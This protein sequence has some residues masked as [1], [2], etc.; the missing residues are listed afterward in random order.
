MSASRF[1]T[2]EQLLEAGRTPGGLTAWFD[3]PLDG[4]TLFDCLAPL[5][6][7]PDR[8]ALHVFHPPWW[9][10]SPAWLAAEHVELRP[11]GSGEQARLVQQLAGVGAGDC[12]VIVEA[13]RFSAPDEGSITGTDLS[14]PAG[15]S[16]IVPWA[17]IQSQRVE[18]LLRAWRQTTH[19]DAAA[20][21]ILSDQPMPGTAS[22]ARSIEA[23]GCRTADIPARFDPYAEADAAVAALRAGAEPAD[24]VR[25]IE[26][27]LP[28]DADMPAVAG[29]AFYLAGDWDRA[30]A[31]LTRSRHPSPAHLA[32]IAHQLGDFE[33]ARRLIA[34]LDPAAMVDIDAL[35]FARDIA[36][37]LSMG[38]VV[39]ALGDRV[40]ALYPTSAL[41]LELRAAQLAE[42]ADWPDL[43]ALV[44]QAPSRSP[45]LDYFGGLAR[46][47]T[48]PDYAVH[49][50]IDQARRLGG[51]FAAE[52]WR[53][54][55]Q[56]L[57]PRQ[58]PVALAR[59]LVASRLK[60][61]RWRA[62][63]ELIDAITAEP[64]WMQPETIELL[65]ALLDVALTEAARDPRDSAIRTTIH[66][67]FRPGGLG[68]E[69]EGLLLVP[70]L[71]PSRA[72]RIKATRAS[73]HVAASE[74]EVWGYIE[75]RLTENLDPVRRLDRAGIIPPEARPAKPASML[76]GLLRALTQSVDVGAAIFRDST[77]GFFAGVHAALELIETAGG[78]L[79]GIGAPTVLWLAG[80]AA[81]ING[82]DQHALQLAET[83]LCR[84]HRDARQRR[85]AWFVYADL[86]ARAGHRTEAL[87]GYLCA[88]RV[89]VGKLG[90]SWYQGELELRLRLARDLGLM[91]VAEQAYAEARR[92]EERHR[93]SGGYNSLSDAYWT[94]RLMA[95]AR[96]APGEGH[97]AAAEV[98]DYFAA[99][100]TV[101]YDRGSNI[102]V[103]LVN[104]WSTM[105]QARRLGVE[106][107]PTIRAEFERVFA[108]MPPADR[109]MLKARCGETATLDDLRLLVAPIAGTRYGADLV[110]H[111][112]NARIV[113]E[114]LLARPDAGVVE[115]LVALEVLADTA[116]A[117]SADEDEALGERAR[118]QARWMADPDAHVPPLR[119]QGT[120]KHDAHPVFELLCAPEAGVQALM[121]ALPTG[122]TLAALA[123]AD[124][125]A[126]RIVD[127]A[128]QRAPGPPQGYRA[129]LDRT[130]A[131]LDVVRSPDAAAATAEIHAA[132]APF[133]VGQPDGAPV[134][135][136]PAADLAALPGNTLPSAGD[137]LGARAPVAML[138]SLCW[139]AAAAERPARAGRLAWVLPGR[140]APEDSVPEDTTPP[141]PPDALG[142]IA[143]RIRPATAPHGFRTGVGHQPPMR[144]D[145]M[146]VVIVVAHGGLDPGE[147]LVRI[148]DEQGR[149]SSTDAFAHR[150]GDADVIIALICHGGRQTPASG[151]PTGLPRRLLVGRTRAVVACPWVLDARAAMDWLP[152]FLDEW[153][154]GQPLA[155]AVFR[156]NARLR[157]SRPHP[158]DWLAMHVF[159]CP[160]IAM[161]P[162][163][164]GAAD[165]DA[166]PG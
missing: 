23:A 59:A 113:A 97:I 67:R 53:S 96:M 158:G 129:A 38:R 151:R 144:I 65:G 89:K 33:Q 51:A 112:R 72:P 109:R 62:A 20:C 123:L 133:D 44:R 153:A 116:I 43:L 12:A 13:D 117:R 60:V 29:Y 105:D 69:V 136:L 66:Q 8:G 79:D 11:I 83:V 107:P 76:R 92:I 115:T 18:A 35:A 119:L 58:E 55:I 127:R 94:C 22:F 166:P 46:L 139:W 121:G 162:I 143:Q 77:T 125:M 150:V 64:G 145:G 50:F 42:A 70:F 86:L 71:S 88:Q 19:H 147:Q 47:A 108:E 9:R 124:A 114:R 7:A 26:A 149:A 16:H 87:I 102:K 104:L 61:P 163:D 111:L 99:R 130:Y 10:P 118:L 157:I 6:E 128:V 40:I 31:Y 30:W 106:V 146:G 75:R 56:V 137:L 63:L 138:P 84:E 32:N 142:W 39:L 25:E 141:G 78:T 90:A 36:A 159:G 41:G 74:D 132:L 2:I 73:R 68:A 52:A 17:S 135:V 54:A 98:L 37:R 45:T 91:P 28:P 49:T 161:P 140:G 122:S 5:I 34:S 48:G 82:Y 101:A 165:D 148:A 131:A 80:Q 103:I 14:G 95:L 164:D 120:L 57:E 1:E 154:A 85:R 110:L 21:F 152:L 156:A 15:A 160:D 3:L 134:L 155:V 126:V 93:P 4:P 24:V 100:L 81:V 27:R